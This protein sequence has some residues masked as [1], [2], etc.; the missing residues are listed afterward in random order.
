M[1]GLVWAQLLRRPFPDR[2]PDT[3]FPPCL[4]AVAKSVF[5]EAYA[6]SSVYGITATSTRVTTTYTATCFNIIRL[7]CWSCE[8][9]LLPSL[10]AII[11]II[12]I[13]NIVIVVSH[14]HHQN[15]GTAQSQSCISEAL[16]HLATVRM[17]QASWQDLSGPNNASS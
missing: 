8:S 10:A 5:D 7:C 11:I 14:H 2:H 15:K 12:I 1:S 13:I 6:S 3:K 17:K 4:R 9:S 16:N